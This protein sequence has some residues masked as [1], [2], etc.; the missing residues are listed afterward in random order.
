MNI[1]LLKKLSTLM[2]YTM[3]AACVIMTAHV[4]GLLCGKNFFFAEWFCGFSVLGFAMLF[5]ASYV[6]SYDNMFR[7]LLVYDFAIDQCIVFQRSFNI[8]GEF[9]TTARLIAATIGI[10]LIVI[11]ILTANTYKEDDTFEE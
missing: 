6:L 5:I 8:F 11:F 10:I 1:E 3:F 4:V 7:A 2:K 9:L